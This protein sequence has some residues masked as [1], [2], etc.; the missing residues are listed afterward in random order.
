MLSGLVRACRE[1]GCR[2]HVYVLMTNHLVLHLDDEKRKGW[3]ETEV[4]RRW[5]ML[6]Q[7]PPMVLRWQRGEPL[8]DDDWRTR[9]C[10]LSRRCLNEPLARGA[11][12]EDDC[13]GRFWEGLDN[14][15][16]HQP[17]RCQ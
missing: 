8:L 2:V 11:K 12:Q 9:L 1:D 17:V 10:D 15:D 14:R 13:T 3:S 6:F 4:V 7:L 5:A 16:T